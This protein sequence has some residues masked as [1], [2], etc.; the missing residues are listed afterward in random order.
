MLETQTVTQSEWQG[1][2]WVTGTLFTIALILLGVVW[3]SQ[4]Q[5]QRDQITEQ[6]KL[7]ELVSLLV[8]DIAVIKNNSQNMNRDVEDIRDDV[9]KIK[10]NVTGIDKRVTRLEVNK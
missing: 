9:E 3:R 1:L 4:V 2:I 7:N 10:E 8:T 5:T 6:K